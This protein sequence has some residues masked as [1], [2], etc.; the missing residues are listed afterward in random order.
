MPILEDY[1]ITSVLILGQNFWNQNH[2]SIDTK[3][4]LLN[5]PL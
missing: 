2:L 5:L 4:C 3:V 1:E